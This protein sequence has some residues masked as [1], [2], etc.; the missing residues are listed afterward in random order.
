MAQALSTWVK[1]I[2][3]VQH[4]KKKHKT[5]IRR[6]KRFGLNLLIYVGELIQISKMSSCIVK[7]TISSTVP[8]V[9]WPYL[10][11]SL[12]CEKIPGRPPFY[13]TRT[14]KGGPDSTE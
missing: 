12:M 3:E 8:V 14:R 10:H 5:K 1:Y 6:E 4:P 2:P 13:T 9:Y 11:G 7:I